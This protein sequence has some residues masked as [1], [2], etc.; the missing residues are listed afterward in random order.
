[1]GFLNSQTNHKN[2]FAGR[3]NKNWNVIT[4]YPWCIS[5][6]VRRN[7]SILNCTPPPPRHIKLDY[8]FALGWFK[9]WTLIHLIPST[10]PLNPEPSPLNNPEPRREP[11][12]PIE[13]NPRPAEPQRQ[14]EK[15]ENK[16]PS[17]MCRNYSLVN[18]KADAS[19]RG[20]ATLWKREARQWFNQAESRLVNTGCHVS[21][22]LSPADAAQRQ[23][24]LAADW[25][26]L[27]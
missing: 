25:L 14:K 9:K 3:N 13:L 4:C 10:V 15:K 26:R 7:C 18:R 12:E 20:W 2:M 5:S 22:L 24:G 6:D 17:V 11:V 19:I 8:I 21:A 27:I 1:M 16:F 23:R